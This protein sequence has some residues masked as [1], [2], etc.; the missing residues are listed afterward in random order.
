MDGW[1][2]GW[3]GGHDVGG[4]GKQLVALAS[5]ENSGSEEHETRAANPHLR[6][7]IGLGRKPFTKRPVREREQF[8]REGKTLITVGVSNA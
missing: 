3:E 1:V 6:G 8:A 2:D 4:P 5:V 7:S